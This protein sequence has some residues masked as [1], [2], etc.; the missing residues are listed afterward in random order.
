VTIGQTA[1]GEESRAYPF[2]NLRQGAIV[3]EA[4]R[5]LNSTERQGLTT[6]IGE[7]IRAEVEAEPGITMLQDKSIKTRYPYG[8]IEDYHNGHDGQFG[9]MLVPSYDKLAYDI[10]TLLPITLHLIANARLGSESSGY[11]PLLKFQNDLILND[12]HSLVVY[13][14]SMIDAEVAD[15]PNRKA[16]LDELVDL[17]NPVKEQTLAIMLSRE[18]RLSKWKKALGDDNDLQP[19]PAGSY[20]S[21]ETGVPLIHHLSYLELTVGPDNFASAN[22]VYMGAFADRLNG[23]GSKSK[24]TFGLK[25]LYDLYL[26]DKPGFLAG[27]HMPNAGTMTFY[28]RTNKYTPNPIVNATGW[29]AKDVDTLGKGSARPGAKPGQ[30]IILMPGRGQEENLAFPTASADETKYMSQALMLLAGARILGIEDQ[31]LAQKAQKKKRQKK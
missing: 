29:W 20:V 7:R 28:D 18:M 16:V 22:T 14:R 23:H 3:H 1:K 25:R 26:H 30:A 11:D 4:L 17:I 9:D 13:L 8:K 15:S 6:E 5:L 27:G 21:Q 10:Q 12:P 24:P 2:A 31:L 19:I